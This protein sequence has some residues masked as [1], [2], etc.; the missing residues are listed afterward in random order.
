MDELDG[1]KL[2]KLI[3]VHYGN[4]NDGLSRIGGIDQARLAFLGSQRHLYHDA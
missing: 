2:P 3:A 1:D 4:L